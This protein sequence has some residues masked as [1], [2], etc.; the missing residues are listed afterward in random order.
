MALIIKRRALPLEANNFDKVV[1]TSFL[2]V[3]LLRLTT[4]T[5]VDGW[6]QLWEP[7]WTPQ[8]HYR[9]KNREELHKS[10]IV[11]IFFM[12]RHSILQVS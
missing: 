3:L 5:L 10:K 2:P 11:Q 9:R 4:D 8:P 6:P 1:F 7:R 12:P